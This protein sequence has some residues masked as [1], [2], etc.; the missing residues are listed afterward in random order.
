MTPVSLI[1][2]T[3]YSVCRYW[4]HLRNSFFEAGCVKAMHTG[5]DSADMNMVWSETPLTRDDAASLSRIQ[6][7]FFTAGLPFWFWVFPS[8]KTAGTLDVLKSC[9]LSP[10]T[11][12]PCMLSNLANHPENRTHY[13]G[14]TA[15]RVATSE[16]LSIWTNV[17]FQGFD[18]SAHT[19]R[20][21][22]AFIERFDL[23]DGSPQHLLLAIADRQ[24]V[25]A[26]LVFFSEYG[27]AIYFLTTLAECRRQGLGLALTQATLQHAQA[28]G[29]TCA[30]LQSSPDGFHVYLNAGFKEYCRVDIYGL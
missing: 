29:A 16:D 4:G 24:A 21:L 9:G 25:G 27:A 12:M 20:Q 13:S 22:E 7:G 17:V 19:R 14:L 11:S 6:A 23:S 3:F 1:E 2:K 28:G 5:I 18:F 30:M 15:K 26:S 10:V 8:A